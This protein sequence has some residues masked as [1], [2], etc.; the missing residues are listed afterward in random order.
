MREIKKAQDK[1]PAPKAH[2]HY[3]RA[4][5][6]CLILFAISFLLLV[7]GQAVNNERCTFT[8]IGMMCASGIFSY[9]LIESED[10]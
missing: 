3:N 10:R 4:Y 9:V 1:S 5:N 6:A 7:I 8:A 2:N